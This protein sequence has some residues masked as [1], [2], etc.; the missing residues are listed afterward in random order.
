MSMTC[1]KLTLLKIYSSLMSL[2]L[3]QGDWEA[4]KN[5][6]N[7]EGQL[8][9]QKRKGGSITS[10]KCLTISHNAKTCKC[11]LHQKEKFLV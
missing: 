5:N 1:F 3:N 9:K 11:E 7:N 4:I 10:N 2:V 8:L 6:Q